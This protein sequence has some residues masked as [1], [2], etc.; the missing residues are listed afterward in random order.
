MT[1][2]LLK[3]VGGAAAAALAAS[4]AGAQSNEASGGYAAAAITSGQLDEAERILQPASRADANDPARLL[5][6]ATV[7][8]RTARFVEAREALARVQALPSE[9]LELANGNSYSSHAIAAAMLGRLEGR[10]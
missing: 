4:A 3:I 6:M 9:P 7:Y 10:R 8:A 2:T 1:V 5:N